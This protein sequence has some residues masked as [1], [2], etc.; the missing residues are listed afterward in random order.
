M[1]Q[2]AEAE[3]WGSLS[4]A[5]VGSVRWRALRAARHASL[6]DGK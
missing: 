1:D 5:G 3:T 6:E 4:Q 2:G